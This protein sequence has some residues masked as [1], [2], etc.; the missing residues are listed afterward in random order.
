MTKRAWLCQSDTAFRPPR[1]T[2]SSHLRAHCRACPAQIGA[3]WHWDICPRAIE[4]GRSTRARSRFPSTS[5]IPH[6]DPNRISPPRSQARRKTAPM[7]SRRPISHG[8]LRAVRIVE[9]EYLRLRYRIHRPKSRIALS[10]GRRM[11]RVAFYLGRSPRMAFD[12]HAARESALRQGPKR[13][14]G[15][16]RGS[17]ARAHAHTERFF[18]G[19]WRV[20]EVK[21][22]KARDAPITCKNLRRPTLSPHSEAPSGNSRCK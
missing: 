5:A 9:I 2:P 18:P 7:C 19:G 17:T 11:D 15:V 8:H 13:K 22:A 1:Q 21:P 6:P 10:E 4:S 3:I 16:F 14:T 12:Q 20:Q